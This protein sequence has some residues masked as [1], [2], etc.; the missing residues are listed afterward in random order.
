MNKLLFVVVPLSLFIV[1]CGFCQAPGTKLWEVPTAGR[2]YS[3]PAI[4][5]DGTIYVGVSG[6]PD[7]S[8]LTTNGWVYSISPHGTTNWIARTYGD[9]RSSPAIGPD[10]TIYIGSIFGYLYAFRPD[11][12]TNW[13]DTTGDT[14]YRSYIGSSP[15]IGADGTIYINSV[16]GYDYFDRLFAI[17]PNGTTNWVLTLGWGRRD[18]RFEHI[19]YSSPII[20]PD[21][22]IYVATRDKNLFA[23]TPKGTTN[24]VFAIGTNTSCSPA[25]GP[26]GTIYL[27][28]DDRKFYA[29]D[30]QG[31]K[32]WE[33]R[34]GDVIESSAAIAG[35]TIYFASLDQK[36]YALDF[37]GNPRWILTNSIVSSSPLLSADGTIYVQDMDLGY[38][39]F[40]AISPSGSTLWTFTSANDDGIASPTVGPDGTI[41]LA[42]NSLYALYGNQHL[43]SSSWPMFR[44]N[45]KHTGRSI[46]RGVSRPRV[47]ADG[48]L[49]MDFTIETGRT[50]QVEYSTNV[51]EWAELT[52]FVSSTFTNQFIDTTSASSAQ[53]YYRLRTTM[54]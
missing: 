19:L 7:F 46:Q 47:W 31:S 13:I 4:A 50:Y 40:R 27:G 49:A 22:T 23:I 1:E 10:G 12:T 54:P 34:T 18:P 6:Q 8:G 52:N 21:G 5:D 35:D 17:R 45:T 36:F 9:V 33:F 14:L 28:A 37:S 15:A 24:W 42:G 29:I 51:L 3:S 38:K 25:I 20:G 26:D 44:G 16:T 32:K 48:N 41:Y 53:R 30:P 2:I 39:G 11:G 43:M